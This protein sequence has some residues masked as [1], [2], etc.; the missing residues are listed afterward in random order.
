MGEEEGTRNVPPFTQSSNRFCKNSQI[1]KSTKC[2]DG[3]NTSIR[4]KTNRDLLTHIHTQL[5]TRSPSTDTVPGQTT[6]LDFHI[7]SHLAEETDK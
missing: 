1:K 3:P 6:S 4:E 5:P 7:M 2:S